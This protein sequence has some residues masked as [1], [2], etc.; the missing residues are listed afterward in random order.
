MTAIIIE[1]ILEKLDSIDK[2]LDILLQKKEEDIKTVVP[3]FKR[4]VDTYTFFD[5]GK[6]IEQMIKENPDTLGECKWIFYI[7]SIQ[8]N[9][10][11]ACTRTIHLAQIGSETTRKTFEEQKEWAKQNNCSICTLR[12]MAALC[13]SA[14]KAGKT[15]SSCWMRVADEDKRGDCLIVQFDEDGLNLAYSFN[16]VSNSG[17]GL[18]TSPISPCQV[19]TLANNGKTE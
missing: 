16:F 1:P 4:I 14:K 18:A 11:D 17:Q 13:L 9:A 6:S 15:L 5:D 2:K 10:E 12:Q 8:K 3:A 7:S 19:Q